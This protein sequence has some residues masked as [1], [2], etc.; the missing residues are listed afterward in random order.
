MLVVRLSTA[1]RAILLEFAPRTKGGFAHVNWGCG[2]RRKLSWQTLRAIAGALA[3]AFTA[4]SLITSAQAGL[5][6]KILR[7]TAETGADAGKKAAR[8]FSGLDGA[9]RVVKELPPDTRGVAV[10]AAATPEGHW[11][12][13]NAAGETVTAAGPDEI[14]NALKW[15]APE[16]AD[17]ARRDAAFY[18]PV[19]TA[20]ARADAFKDLPKSARL[21]VVLKNKPYRL[22]VGGDGAR[23]ALVR[24]RLALELTDESLVKEALW[25]LD[26]P[27]NRHAIRLLS[28][29][30]GGPKALARTR[31]APGEGA[32]LPESIDPYALGKALPGLRGQTVVVTGAV[33]NDILYFKPSSGPEARL[34]I[35]D[36]RK[37]AVEADVNLVVLGGASTSQPGARNMLWQRVEV[38]GLEEALDKATMGDF[39]GALGFERSP[40]VVGLAR[41]GNNHVLINAQPRPNLASQLPR[42]L[43]SREPGTLERMFTEV[44]SSVL[45][46]VA[47][48]GVAAALRSSS[49]EKE[50]RQRIVPGVPS[51]YQFIYLGFL[52]FGLFGLPMALAWWRRLWPLPAASSHGSTVSLVF[53]GSGRLLLFVLLFLPLVALVATPAHL[54]KR[55]WDFVTAP[56]RWFGRGAT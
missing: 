32:P 6:T 51:D 5:L 26:R 12:F 8:G 10:A 19:E 25:Q 47:T 22:M 38:A 17:L 33:R 30:P 43:A 54:I 11:R 4:S 9:A 46:N 48:H 3:V 39:L 24:D 2:Y 52:V 45:G 16:T 15:L 50:L 28:L 18:V 27:V 36:L 31:I 35:S 20:I 1:L 49:Y 40:I 7:Q 55:A 41:H 13:T 44:V 29:E 21:Y 34:V 42:E 56:F 53:Y 37:A 23:Y 14:K